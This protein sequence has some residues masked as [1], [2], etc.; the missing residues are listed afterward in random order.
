MIE[1]NR[2]NV[3]KFIQL[4]WNQ[5]AFSLAKPFLDIG[6]V[7]QGSFNAELLDSVGFLEYVRAIREAVADF[8]VTVEEMVAENDAVVT[9]SSITGILGKPL[10]GFPPSDRVVS[11]PV[12]SIYH[13]RHGRIR[14]L[15]STYDVAAIMNLLG[16]SLTKATAPAA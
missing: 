13:L 11:L 10:F 15:T 9:Y 8:N 6:F 5:G 1:E 3:Q 16:L 2:R 12:V 4:A 14:N 7:Y